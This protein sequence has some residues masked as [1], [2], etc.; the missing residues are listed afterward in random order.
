MELTLDDA[1]FVELSSQIKNRN[2]SDSKMLF[3]E[4]ME[5]EERTSS[6]IIKELKKAVSKT[7]FYQNVKVSTFVDAINENT[8]LIN[9]YNE[10]EKKSFVF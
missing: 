7:K 9:E 6:E 10:K 8:F 2:G 1:S 4:N 5:K 3:D